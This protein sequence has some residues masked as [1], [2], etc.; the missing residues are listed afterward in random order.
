MFRAARL[1]ICVSLVCAALASAVERDKVLA[2]IPTIEDDELREALHDPIGY[3]YDEDDLP[4][5]YPHDARIHW[6][7]YNISGGADRFGSGNANVEFPWRDGGGLNRAK[8]FQTAKQIL[9]PR[10][11]GGGRWEIVY[12]EEIGSTRPVWWMFPIGTRVHEIMAVVHDDTHYVFEIRVL[13]RE[14]DAWGAEVHRQFWSVGELADAIEKTE[15]RQLAN[16]VRQVRSTRVRLY[17]SR[18]PVSAFDRV[19][20]VAKLPPLPQE[21]TLQLLLDTPLRFGG[22][23]DYGLSADVSSV[24]PAG[25]LGGHVGVARDDCV[26]CHRHAGRHVDSFGPLGRDWYGHVRG[27]D[28][29]FSWYPYVPSLTTS[30]DAGISTNGVGAQASVWNS[31][32][33]QGWLQPYDRRKHP[34]SIYRRIAP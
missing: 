18:H 20:N 12:G 25:Y 4:R 23:E 7:W 31:W 1:A 24:V 9:L 2:S 13:I 16:Q 26:T 14:A 6:A 3:W 30:S 10:K 11:E 28:R 19:A 27:G 5:A 21:L 32:I 15:Y 17:D 29:I 22:N 34:S 8:D 33:Q